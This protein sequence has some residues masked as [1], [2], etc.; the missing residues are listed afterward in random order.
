MGYEETLQYIHAV[1][2]RGQKPG[3]ERIRALLECI[4]RPDRQLKFVHIGGTNGKGSTAAMVESVLRQAGYRTGLYTSPYINRFNE[5][6]RVNGVHISDE[7]LE[8]AVNVLRPFADSMED[9]PSEFELITAVAMYFFARQKCDIVVLEVGL[10]G[11]FDA[12]NVI[13]CPEVAVMTTI[14]LDHTAVLGTTL[15]E[16]ARTKAGIIKH[17]CEVVCYPPQP[18]AEKEIRAACVSASATCRVADFS[19]LHI[20]ALRDGARCFD[21]AGKTWQIPLLAKYQPCNAAVAIET[22]YVLQRRG[23]HVTEEN[24][25]QGLRN[26]A[27]QGRFELLSDSPVFVLDGSHNPQ[28]IAATVESLQECFPDGRLIL[29]MSVMA[30][31]DADAMLNAVVPLAKQVFT[32]TADNPR[33]MTAQQ[34]AEKIRALGCDA[35]ACDSVAQGVSLAVEE[36]KDG[37]PI[38]A[39]GT[40]Y[41]SG[42]VRN[43]LHETLALK[44]EL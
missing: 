4:G 3:L 23:W 8:Q 10:G 31:K 20:G 41:F 36:A 24:I 5:R 30:D 7:D 40:L 29:L 27:W 38:C 12:T 2:W 33:A 26:V 6:I 39:L 34:L 18:E 37:V 15:S 1:Q 35:V 22:V 21:F 25:A 14:S 9:L 43:A 28:G 19:T 17:G 42:E 44:K 32:V 11:E 13:D 16:I